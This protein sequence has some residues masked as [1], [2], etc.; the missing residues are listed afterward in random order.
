VLEADGSTDAA[1]VAL[2]P[3]QLGAGRRTAPARRAATDRD[4]RDRAAITIRLAEDRYW[5]RAD[6][7][8][9]QAVLDELLAGPVGAD[10]RARDLIGAHRPMFQI[11]SGRIDDGLTEVEP[12]VGDPDPLVAMLAE[13]PRNI[14]AAL[15]GR[16][17]EA[18]AQAGL[19]LER[20]MTESFPYLVNP[21]HHVVAL[22]W[23]MLHDGNLA[24]ATR[25]R[26][27]STPRRDVARLHRPG[28]AALGPG[29]RAPRTGRLPAQ[30]W[31]P[32][33]CGARPASAS[34]GQRRPA[35]ARLARPVDDRPGTGHRWGPASTSTRNQTPCSLEVYVA[36]PGVGSL[37]RQSSHQAYG[38]GAA[39]D[40]GRA[41][42]RVLAAGRPTTSPG[43]RP[44]LATTRSSGSVRSRCR[45]P[46][47]FAAHARAL[48]GTD[49][50]ELKDVAAG[51]STRVRLYG[52][53]EAQATRWAKA[54]S[55][56]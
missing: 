29:H 34:P 40:L 4:P 51:F 25:S 20:A 37:G 3:C 6:P 54:R 28:W 36:R 44:D 21:G 23:S 47:L 48:A 35:R 7:D 24:G 18:T 15:I 41:Q 33:R 55:H 16:C 8:G 26:S 1:I 30:P 2:V 10:A 9:T 22:G 19:A 12:Y 17:T 27:W 43:C 31:R 13:V 50:D 52:R 14:G 46:R 42:G 11:L 38:L 5:G 53:A 32:R 49:L 39:V 56:P 45:M